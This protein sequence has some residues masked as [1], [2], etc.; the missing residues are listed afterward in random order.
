MILAII[1]LLAHI[2]AYREVEIL[3]RDGSWPLVKANIPFWENILGIKNTDSFHFMQGLYWLIIVL[4]LVL[5]GYWFYVYE[6]LLIPLHL[7]LLGDT[8]F[9][10][11]LSALLTILIYWQ[12][13]M[14]FR[15]IGM[16]ISFISKQYREWRYLSPIN[17]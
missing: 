11:I 16:H 13:Y 12:S 17:L 5:E 15:N 9:L 10:I 7:L 1:F 3:I 4:F 8:L 6:K 2:A 14:Y